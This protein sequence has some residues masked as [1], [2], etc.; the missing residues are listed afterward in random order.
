MLFKDKKRKNA[1]YMTVEATVVVSVMLLVVMALIYSFMLMYQFE[2]VQHATTVGAERGATAFVIATREAFD[3]NDMS[4]V[5]TETKKTVEGI[6][7]K[8][9]ISVKDTQI[10]V[11]K[12]KTGLPFSTGI[13]VSIHQ[14]AKVPLLGF[15]NDLGLTKIGIY[16]SVAVA[17]IVAPQDTIRNTD[18]GVDIAK[19]GIATSKSVLTSGAKFLYSFL[20]K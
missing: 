18:L 3:G 2:L 9:M 15:F 17:E 13:R 7:K 6:L 14:D 4:T 1:G 16:D 19:R 20:K 5:V 10:S 12:V 11:D 8:S